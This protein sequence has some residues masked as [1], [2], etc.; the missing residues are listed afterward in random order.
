MATWN[1]L[2]WEALDSSRRLMEYERYRSSVNRAYFAA[3]AKL[4]S[5]LV[6]SRSVAFANGNNPTHQQ[7]PDLVLNHLPHRILP[8]HRRRDIKRGIENLRK[9]RI[10]ADYAPQSTIQ[11]HEALQ[12]LKLACDIIQ[13]VE[14]L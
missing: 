13:S 5:A 7:L 1:E 8:L 14:K 2:S 4:T 11:R 9:A 3:Y 12:A 10:E 6:A